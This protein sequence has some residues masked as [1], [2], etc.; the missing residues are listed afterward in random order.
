M[1]FEELMT[2]GRAALV[3]TP[4]LRRTLSG[5]P[6]LFDLLLIVCSFA[7]GALVAWCVRKVF[8]R[9]TTAHY[10]RRATVDEDVRMEIVALSSDVAW[11]LPIAAVCLMSWVKGMHVWLVQA[12]WRVGL[13]MVTLLFVGVLR[14]GVN[15]LGIWYRNQPGA[16]NRPIDGLLVT[17]RVF[18]YAAGAVCAVSV[19]ADKT[20]LYMLSAVGAA[21]AVL[22]LVFQDSLLSLAASVQVNS[23]R[24]VNIGDWIVQED[25]G[26]DG[27][28]EAMTLHT[29]KVRNWDATVVALP[30]RA[31]VEESFVNMTRMQEGG[32]RRYKRT[33][34]IDF[35][36]VRFLRQVE[37]EELKRFDLLFED[38]PAE[39]GMGVADVKPHGPSVS[40]ERHQTNLGAFRAYLLNYLRSHPLICQDRMM[41]A[42][43][44]EPTSQGVPLE[45]YAFARKTDYVGFSAVSADI[46]EHVLA[47]LPSFRLRMFQECSDIYQAVGDK[48]ENVDGVFTYETYVQPE[49]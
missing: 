33:F 39:E 41:L 3:F 8:V 31:L 6:Y 1:N 13:A 11:M 48:V 35:R 26:V 47:V 21:A 20:P 2:S 46:T 44:L 12:L 5:C 14:H 32:G 29:V 4:E 17:V 38:N 45:V 37:L 16:K 40:G 27:V 18:I 36:S 30:V 22:M 7:V 25:K 42:T 43:A 23:N 34:L 49:A 19:L 10:A 28:V 9:L 24:L 15:L